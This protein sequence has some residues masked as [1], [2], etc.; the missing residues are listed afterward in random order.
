MHAVLQNLR[1]Y[2][3]RER[4]DRVPGDQPQLEEATLGLRREHAEWWRA[5]F[6]H[7]TEE[8][9]LSASRKYARV[10]AHVGA[11]D[12]PHR[13]GLRSDLATQT[14]VYDP[15]RFESDGL[16]CELA[17][18]ASAMRALWRTTHEVSCVVLDF[19]CVTHSTVARLMRSASAEDVRVGL[20]LWSSLPCRVKRVE[21]LP[22]RRMVGWA[23][24]S[25]VGRTFLSKKM[26]ERL[27]ILSGTEGSVCA[28]LLA[29]GTE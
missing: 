11:T 23:A 27:H 21:I 19:R 24:V 8:E 20:D 18:G 17:A 4:A 25:A 10:I 13:P 16:A 12:A 28:A 22:P 5:S 15:S 6:P 2:C 14:L 7:K 26:S 29:R 3:K 1:E 9:A